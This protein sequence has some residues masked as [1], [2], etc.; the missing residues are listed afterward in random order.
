MVRRLDVQRRGL[1]ADG[2]HRIR[3]A[4]SHVR[5]EDVAHR[6]R[7]DQSSQLE[8]AARRG[9]QDGA[10]DRHVVVFHSAPELVCEQVLRDVPQVLIL[11]LQQE[12]ADIFGPVNRGAVVHLVTSVDGIAFIF[13][14]EP[15]DRVELLL[16]GLKD[17]DWDICRTAAEQAASLG[18]AGK[19]AVPVLAELLRSKVMVVR[20]A[21]LKSLQ[22]LDPEAKVTLP[23]LQ[24]ALLQPQLAVRSWA[25]EQIGNLKAKGAPAAPLLT[26]LVGSWRGGVR[27]A[28]V[29]AQNNKGG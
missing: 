7:L 11:I 8:P 9:L 27:C 16:N 13:R 23:G 5:R 6:D 20:N 4:F 14:S 12:L 10:N 2:T 28:L 25:A 17:P 18:E 24:E 19:Q 1:L 3:S 22:D 21:A 29:G 15:A 26:L